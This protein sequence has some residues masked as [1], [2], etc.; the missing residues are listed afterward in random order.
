MKQK[1][2]LEHFTACPKR[3][4]R[5]SDKKAEK[6]LRSLIKSINFGSCKSCLRRLLPSLH[7][8][9]VAPSSS[10]SSPSAASS[11]LIRFIPFSF[12]HIRSDR[13]REKRARKTKKKRL[14]ARSKSFIFCLSIFWR[15]SARFRQLNVRANCRLDV[16]KRFICVNDFE[17]IS[18]G[19]AQGDGFLELVALVSPK[20]P[21]TFESVYARGETLPN[22]SESRAGAVIVARLA[23]AQRKMRNVR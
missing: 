7:R 5:T 6:K 18:S 16:R 17:S 21:Q 15:K 1:T 3:I 11:S 23:A 10:S 8:F 12:G 14:N 20:C 13:S 4:G 9:P 22:E 19:S 2:A